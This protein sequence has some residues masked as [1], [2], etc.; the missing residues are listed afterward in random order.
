ME[1][2]H[3]P[4]NRSSYPYDLTNVKTQASF[5]IVAL[6]VILSNKILDIFKLHVKACTLMYNT[7]TAFNVLEQTFLSPKIKLG[8]CIPNFT[9]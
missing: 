7:Y 2:I 1:K 5:R 8:K 9:A 3:K 6:Q 4:N